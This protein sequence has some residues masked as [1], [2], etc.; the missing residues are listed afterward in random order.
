MSSQGPLPDHCLLWLATL[1]HWKKIEDLAAGD[2]LGRF[3][4][5][6][7]RHQRHHEKTRFGSQLKQGA[8]N[9]EMPLKSQP[10]GTQPVL[11]ESQVL[12]GQMFAV[13]LSDSAPLCRT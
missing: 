13:D 5:P 9:R 12:F 10:P 3:A 4:M 7:P 2:L 8:Y 1:V 6:M 11:L